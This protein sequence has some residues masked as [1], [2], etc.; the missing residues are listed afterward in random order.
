[1]VVQKHTHQHYNHRTIRTGHLLLH[2]CS[3]SNFSCI[4]DT[5]FFD[6]Y[7]I[8]LT[9]KV[10]ETSK[11]YIGSST[12]KC[13]HGPQICPTAS[14]NPEMCGISSYQHLHQMH[15]SSQ[16]GSPVASD[17]SSDGVH[18]NFPILPSVKIL[19]LYH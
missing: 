14:C 19:L 10:P 7:K 5:N 4:N 3:H 8:L 16:L 6:L 17:A 12:Y 18:Q 1:M 9:I 11:L 13:Q 2:N 15:R